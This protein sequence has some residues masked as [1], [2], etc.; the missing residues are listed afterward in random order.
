MP[1]AAFLPPARVSF[2][3]LAYATCCQKLALILC[4]TSA[5]LLLPSDLCLEQA[6]APCWFLLLFEQFLLFL[7]DELLNL[8]H[9][10]FKDLRLPRNLWIIIVQVILGVFSLACLRVI[11]AAIGRV[12]ILKLD[13]T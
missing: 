9:L 11:E 4:Q 8:Y 7:F 1:N 6:G 13:T 3:A 2:T 12:V 10:A 5:L